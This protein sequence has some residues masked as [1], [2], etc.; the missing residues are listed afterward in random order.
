[1]APLIAEPAPRP[2]PPPVPPQP[3]RAPAGPPPAGAPSALA[4]PHLPGEGPE[5]P[6]PLAH[7]P[8]KR[9][10]PAA[11][12]PV[13]RLESPPPAS[14]V[15][16]SPSTREPAASQPRPAGPR[17]LVAADLV[18]PAALAATPGP[19]AMG[20]LAA[21]PS[22]AS[23]SHAPKPGPVVLGARP[24]SSGALPAARAIRPPRRRGLA[25]LSVGACVAIGLALGVA[26]VIAYS[27][28]FGLPLP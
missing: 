24:E 3:T 20:P 27:V 19:I 4:E 14:G 5:A 18:D 16:S 10:R 8:R 2:A 26:V 22:G 17:V 11:S 28:Y 7:R 23:H 9:R 1:L 25:N 6:G 12:G 15:L 21:H 13:L